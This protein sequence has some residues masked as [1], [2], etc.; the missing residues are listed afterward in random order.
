[1]NTRIIYRKTDTPGELSSKAIFTGYGNSYRVFV[2]T[3]TRRYQITD[4]ISGQVYREG[5]TKS[6]YYTKL[7]AKQELID[8]GVE[9]KLELRRTKDK[10]NYILAEPTDAA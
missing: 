2:N 5:V 3:F 9:F 7:K 10:Y 6:P 4:A 8:L 1:M